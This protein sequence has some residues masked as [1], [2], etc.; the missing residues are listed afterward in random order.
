MI[1][2][3]SWNKREQKIVISYIDKNGNRK[4]YQKYMH[5]IKTYEYDENGA[6]DTWNNKKCNK[7]YKD[8]STYRP[9]EFDMLEFMF[10]MK[11]TDDEF[12]LNEFHAN[13]PI[14]LY[15]YDIETKF[16]PG[17]F[18]DPDLA[19][20]EVTSISLV[21]PDLSCIVYGFKE[22]TPMKIATLKQRY[23][24]FIH[25]N[26]FASSVLK[27]LGK[28]PKVLYQKFDT[29]AELLR[30]WFNVIIPKIA[31]LGGWNS[32]RFDRKYLV[33]RIKR[34]FGEHE[35][36][37][38]I[39]NGSPTREIS[40]VSWEEQSGERDYV[41]IPLHM[42]EVDYMELVKQYEYA[43]RPY[44]S[45]SLDWCGEHIVKANKIKYN[46]TLQELYDRDY[47]WYYYYNAIDSLIVQLLHQRVKCIKSP[48]AVASVTL[49][50]FI[51]SF[52][53]VALTT[54]NLFKEFYDA[55]QHVVYDFN[56][57]D[58]NR[59]PYEGAF[60]GC[61]PGLR[62][63]AACFDFKSLYPSQIR[64]C[65]FSFENFVGSFYDFKTL[66]QYA[67]PEK[68]VMFGPVV[69]ENK[70]TLL[71]PKVGKYIG[72]FINEEALVPY[73]KDKNY[74]VSVMGNVYKND[75]DYAFKRMQTR[76]TKGRDRYK[77]TG[78]KIEAQLLSEIDR[79]IKE[80]ESS[81]NVA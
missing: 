40:K 38:M 25:E 14:R 64:T 15:T 51:A 12:Y 4:M 19:N 24:N 47:E 8:S 59:T 10:D 78:Q 35:A 48:A 37:N 46:G 57:I 21:G 41:N 11:G 44:E 81:N 45:Y 67:D 23:L 68:F 39:R 66:K 60:C 2:D 58:R 13:Y 16:E 31:F 76:N 30:H 22:M 7:V 54:A 52:G 65:N 3:R 49:V 62:N 55:K 63:F 29:E 56:E 43:F 53:Q 33:N 72:K 50:P 42:V 17:V 27:M 77:Y 75:K 28:E 69:Y 1:I 20:Q 5:H 34:L 61:V 71:K 6:F 36:M 74:F 32:Y 70:G 73:R 9:N 26:E 18:P 80:K 79:L